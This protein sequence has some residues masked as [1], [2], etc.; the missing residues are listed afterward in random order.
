MEE[1][2]LPKSTPFPSLVTAFAA[3]HPVFGKKNND[4]GLAQC[5]R[6][7]VL[8]RRVR[9]RSFPGDLEPGRGGTRSGRP[10]DGEVPGDT[11]E[12]PFD[13][14]ETSNWELGRRTR[15]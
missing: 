6:T 8:L 7:V 14:G 10:E 9:P 1:V 11:Q 15:S 4:A 3:Q 5:T 13:S 2:V 12:F